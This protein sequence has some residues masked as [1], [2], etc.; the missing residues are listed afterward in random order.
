M[1][2]LVALLVC[3]IPTTIGGLA[4]RH[5]HRRHGPRDPAQRHGHERPRRRS[6][7]RRGRPA[8]RQDRHDHPR[9]PH[10]HRVS[11]PRRGSAGTLADAAQLASLADETPEGRSIV[12]LA[13]EKFDCARGNAEPHANFVPFTAQTRMSGVDF[14]CHSTAEPAHARA[15]RR[16]RGTCAHYVDQPGG[17]FPQAGD[18][19][20]SMKSRVAAERRSSWRIEHDALGVIASERRR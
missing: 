10:G 2:V 4:Q 16:G 11:F 9:Q 6:R 20:R 15:Q 17:A 12:V 19:R 18:A 8:A 3:L 1:P 7:R 13:K 14:H 5:R